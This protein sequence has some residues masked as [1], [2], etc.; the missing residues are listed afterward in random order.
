MER[1]ECAMPE[2]ASPHL[3]RRC[4]RRREYAQRAKFAA[5]LRDAFVFCAAFSE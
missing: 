5:V 2:F 4:E 1:I 3:F